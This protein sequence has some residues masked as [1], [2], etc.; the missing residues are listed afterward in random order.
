MKSFGARACTIALVCAANAILPAALDGQDHRPG[1]RI[2]FAALHSDG[3][4]E[5]SGF[6]LFSSRNVHIAAGCGGRS[7]DATARLSHGPVR[8]VRLRLNPIA[9]GE[10][11]VR[12]E[13]C[14]N[15]QLDVTLED[16]TALGGGD[17]TVTV[18]GARLNGPGL[19]CGR[20]SFTVVAEGHPITLRGTFAIP[21][22]S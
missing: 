6:L 12:S 18:L 14:P 20:F 4:L 9:I 11:P 22:R 10:S 17:G 13:T 5:V 8:Q 3:G 1:I 19:I 2:H 7:L 21:V 15:A 16:G